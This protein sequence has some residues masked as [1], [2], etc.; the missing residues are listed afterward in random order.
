[1][2]TIS[3]PADYQLNH[4]IIGVVVKVTGNSVENH[5]VSII[6]GQITDTNWQ[7]CQV[8]VSASPIDFPLPYPLY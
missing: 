3:L 6:L 1:M 2:D 4:R 8:F 7:K 5:L